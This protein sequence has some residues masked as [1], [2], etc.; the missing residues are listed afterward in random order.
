MK[1]LMVLSTFFAVTAIFAG[2]AMANDNH[3]ALSIAVPGQVYVNAQSGNHAPIYS[4]ST[5]HE[6]VRQHSPRYVQERHVQYSAPVHAQSSYQPRND[7]GQ[8]NQRHEYAEERRHHREQ[9]RYT[10]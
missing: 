5:P 10:H 9:S 2:T 6:Q 1:K 4:A 8:R 7:H 3:V